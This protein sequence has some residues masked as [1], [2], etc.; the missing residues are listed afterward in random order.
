MP[1]ENQP[2]DPQQHLA[3][4]V[5]QPAFFHKLASHG[6]TPSTNEEAQAMLEIG[7]TLLNQHS[8]NQAKVAQAKSSMVLRAHQGLQEHLSG[9]PAKDVSDAEAV[10]LAS[11]FMQ[12]DATIINSALATQRALIAQPA[13]AGQA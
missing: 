10:K 9:A 3:V 8:Q 1:N 2:Q 4:S 5:A 7:V 13:A 12:H 11:M 6:F